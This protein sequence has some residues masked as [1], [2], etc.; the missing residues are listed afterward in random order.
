MYTKLKDLLYSYVYNPTNE[1]RLYLAD[2]YYDNQQYAAALSYYLQVAEMSEDKDKQYYSL[3]RC[4][5]C[6]EIP[7][8]R[9]HSI[10]TLY[11]HA[12]HLLPD[13]PEAYYFLSKVYEQ[14]AE[15]FDCYTF[16][17]LGLQKNEIDD[18]Y[19]KKL[20]YTS[21]V[22]ILFQKAL[23]AWWIGKGDESRELHAYIIKH[24]FNSMDN[25]FLDAMLGNLK[26]LYK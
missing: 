5:K 2:E 14:H 13:R 3:I 8:N 10:M 26:V 20:Q 6:F 16:S 7:G 25:S 24:Y 15:W 12:I 4:A 17:H 19:S 22:L 9:K 18:I 11:K 23:S 21:K 1:N